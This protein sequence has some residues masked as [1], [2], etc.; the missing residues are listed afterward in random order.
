MYKQSH[1]LGSTPQGIFCQ[2]LFGSSGAFEKTAGAPPFSEWETGDELRKFLSTITRK[3][4]ERYC[5]VLVNALGAGE[6][7]GSNINADYFP[8]NALCHEGDD[9]GYKTFLTAHAFQHHKNKDP[10]RAF[11]IPVLSILNHRMKRVELVVR[12]DREKAKLEGADGIITRIDHGEFPDVSMGCKVPYDVCAK[13]G[14]K[15]KTREDYCVHMSPPP[16][17]RHIYGPNKILPDGVK[18]CVINLHPR[19]FDISF[20]FIG[21]DKTAKVMAKLASRGSMLCMGSVCAASQTAGYELSAGGLFVPEGTEKT[22]SVSACDDSILEDAFLNTDLMGKEAES[23]SRCGSVAASMGRVLPKWAEKRPK[24][25]VAEILKEIP[26]GVFA[27]KRLPVLESQEPDLPDDLLEEAAEHRL[28]KALGALSSMGMILKPH[29]YARMVLKRMGE[30]RL[31]DE[32]EA[33][34]HTFQ[35]VHDFA[36]SPIDMDG[37]VGAIQELLRHLSPDSIKARTAFGE[38]FAVRVRIV[39]RPKI[40]LPTRTPIEHP[41]LD[42]ISAA[43]NGYRRDLLMKLGQATELV[44]RDSKL[45]E[46]VLGEG[47][48]TMFSKTASAPVLSLDSVAYMMSAYMTNRSLLSTTAGAV[49]DESLLPEELLAQGF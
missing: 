26:A 6:Y 17:L 42:K 3:D 30:D 7:F 25:K 31:S 47:L 48:V 18:I 13:C 15:S 10:A 29:E 4:R 27:M 22:A 5:Y 34:N 21:A 23:A 38:P 40:P 28:P 12:L 32:L 20:V 39:V 45:R 49:C 11:G 9:Y 44:Q 46:M 1:F 24:K 14:H 37:V 41:L 19:F 16:E 36:D 43:Y 2:A 33:G 8:W 35:P